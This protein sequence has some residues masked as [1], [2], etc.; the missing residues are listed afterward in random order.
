MLSRVP[1]LVPRSAKLEAR[2]ASAKAA[3]KKKVPVFTKSK[4]NI[5]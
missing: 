5:L 2:L 3:K 1:R 4:C